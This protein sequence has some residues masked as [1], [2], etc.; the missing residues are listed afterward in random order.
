MWHESF[1]SSRDSRA[2]VNRL[3]LH[4]IPVH[5]SHSILHVIRVHKHHL[6]LHMF[7]AHKNHSVLHAI[8]VHV[9]HLVL[10]AIP[11]RANHSVLHVILVHVNHFIPHV[12]CAQESCK[13]AGNVVYS[14]HGPR[15]DLPLSL[16]ELAAD[17]AVLGGVEVL[18]L[19]GVAVAVVGATSEVTEGAVALWPVARDLRLAVVVEELRNHLLAGI[20]LPGN[21]SLTIGELAASF[22]CSSVLVVIE[23]LAK[24]EA[25][26]ARDERQRGKRKNH[27][28]Q[29]MSDRSQCCPDDQARRIEN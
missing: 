7:P 14:V 22:A 25:W 15:F 17:H 20:I 18:L 5:V 28:W 4:V 1:R 2:V 8:P 24:V 9:N 13:E 23:L 11:V 10:H 27:L 19:P 12:I 29:V 3:V 6:V 26:V 21:T 16:E